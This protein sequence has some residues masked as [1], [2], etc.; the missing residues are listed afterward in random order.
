M[1]RWCCKPGTRITSLHTTLS[2]HRQ[3]YYIILQSSL[4]AS[5]STWHKTQAHQAFYWLDLHVPNPTAPGARCPRRSRSSHT[6]TGHPGT[7][8]HRA[9][10]GRLGEEDGDAKAEPVEGRPHLG[11]FRPGSNQPKQSHVGHGLE[12]A[13]SDQERRFQ[14]VDRKVGNR[15]L[16]F[17]GGSL[18]SSTV[19]SRR[20]CHCTC[21]YHQSSMG[22][23]EHKLF[24]NTHRCSHQADR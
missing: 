12:G 23:K 14:T 15:Y 3:S 21:S 13:V 9:T 16:F 18:H 22:T 24:W 17:W 20:D 6:K 4:Q 19:S 11:E 1:C 7:T 2:G 10:E 8:L 5:D